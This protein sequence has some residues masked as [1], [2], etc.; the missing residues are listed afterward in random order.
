[1]GAKGSYGLRA[2]FEHWDLVSVGLAYT[3]CVVCLC[4]Y[5][6]CLDWKN[7]FLDIVSPSRT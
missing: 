7:Y 3:L 5:L 4:S 1:M 6:Y 2:E